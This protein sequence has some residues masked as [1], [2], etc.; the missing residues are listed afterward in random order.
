MSRSIN[1]IIFISICIFVLKANAF[2]INADV[3]INITS[4][5]IECQ[6]IADNIISLVHRYLE[7]PDDAKK[8]YY[9]RKVEKKKK[10][11]KKCQ[12]RAKRQRTP[13]L[14]GGQVGIEIRF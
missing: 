6:H 11:L 8:I 13:Y 12:K 1:K 5:Y 14:A 2:T 7:A 4:K 10:K 9:A 3:D